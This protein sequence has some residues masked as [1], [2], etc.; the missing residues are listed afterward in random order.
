MKKWFVFYVIFKIL[1]TVFNQ[2]YNCQR[3][4]YLGRNLLPKP[5]LSLPSLSWSDRQHCWKKIEALQ[6]IH[7]HRP[8]HRFLFLPCVLLTTRREMCI[9]L[10]YTARRYLIYKH[11]TRRNL[12]EL[13]SVLISWINLTNCSLKNISQTIKKLNFVY[14]Y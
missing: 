8:L 7:V 14:S 3:S 2:S 5:L 11:T 13:S 4:H 12:P 10:F 9:R 1:L 6:I